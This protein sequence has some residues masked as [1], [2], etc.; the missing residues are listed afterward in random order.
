MDG[1]LNK[2]K[3][4][5]SKGANVNAKDKDGDTALS[6]AKTSEIKQFLINNGARE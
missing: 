4:L 2:V 6:I 1:D 5:I 3:S